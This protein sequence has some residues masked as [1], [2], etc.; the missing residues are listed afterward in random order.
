MIVNLS[1]VFVTKHYWPD[2]PANA[3]ATNKT[4][5]HIR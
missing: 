5:K 4:K 3:K 1:E 2:D